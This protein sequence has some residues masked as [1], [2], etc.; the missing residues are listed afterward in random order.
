MIFGKRHIVLGALV[1]ALAGAVYLNYAF[2][3]K[4][5]ALDATDILDTTKNLGDAKLVT[6]SSVTSGNQASTASGTAAPSAAEK[7]VNEYFVNARLNRETTR[8]KAL[9]VINETLKDA[10]LTTEDK[11]N[12]M[13]QLTSIA[14]FIEL[15]GKLE[16]LIKAKGFS[17]CMVVLEGTNCDVIVQSAGLK[18]NESMQIKDIVINTAKLE[19]GNIKITEVK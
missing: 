10:K 16:N 11:N 15:E 5:K 14:K 18:A 9:E 12:A 1:L 4:G 13:A 19:S 2:V 7:T 17:D 6:T 3:S 8:D